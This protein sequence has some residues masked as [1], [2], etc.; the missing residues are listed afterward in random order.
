MDRTDAL[1]AA[2]LWFVVMIYLQT[3]SGSEGPLTLVVDLAALALVF[4]VP[5]VLLGAAV[6]ELAE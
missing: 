6:V 3:G 4:L 2:T 5:L 1:Q